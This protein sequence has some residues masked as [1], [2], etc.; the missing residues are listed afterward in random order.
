MV[1][2]GSCWWQKK[3]SCKWER[4]GSAFTIWGGRAVDCDGDGGVQ[5]G[6]DYAGGWTLRWRE[7]EREVLL[8]AEIGLGRLVFLLSL[9]PN[10]ST[11]GA[12]RSNL[13]I[14]GG[15]GTLCLFWCKILALG[16]TR[17]HPN[18][19]LKVAMMN[20]QFCARKMVGRVGHFEAM[21]LPLQPRSTWMVYTSV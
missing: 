6:G 5:A 8:A 15:R 18:H 20:C 7:R 21:P 9:D 17:K 19:W 10:F 12:W 3:K 1:A 13:F 14:G 4:L 11:H 2:G 16:L